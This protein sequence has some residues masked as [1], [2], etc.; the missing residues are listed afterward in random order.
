MFKLL[1]F[2]FTLLYFTACKQQ[3]RVRDCQLVFSST[4]VEMVMQVKNIVAID[5]LTNETEFCCYPISN[6]NSVNQ[7]SIN[8]FCCFEFYSFSI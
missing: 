5:W 2:M 7:I 1:L 8:Y 3:P 4:H 6:E